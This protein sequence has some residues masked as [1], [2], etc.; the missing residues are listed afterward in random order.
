MSANQLAVTIDDISEANAPA[1]YVKDGLKPFLQ[2][3]KEEVGSQVPD[4]STAKGRDRI[5]SLAA[6]VSKSKVAAEKRENDLKLAAAESERKAEQAKREQIEAEQKAERDRLAAIE[7]QK[8]AVEKAKQDEIA[9]QK[10]AAD[11]I[12]RQEK[13]R[14]ADKA[15]KA[16]INRAALDAFVAGGMTEECAKQAIT[17]IAQRKIPAIAITY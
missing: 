7:N 1:I 2:A 9:R 15:H 5:A 12:L 6:K 13:L 14:E 8:A 17:L 4:L 3:V 16:K 11:E 10:A